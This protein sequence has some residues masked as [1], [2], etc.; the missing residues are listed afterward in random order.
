MPLHRRATRIPYALR[1]PD[2]SRLDLAAGSVGALL[3]RSMSA[4]AQ[5]TPLSAARRSHSVSLAGLGYL[6]V[7]YVIWGSTYLAIRVAVREGAGFPPFAM[8]GSRVLAAGLVLLV[9]AALRGERLRLRRDEL[10]ILAISGLLLWVGGNGLVVWAEQHAGSGY[11]ALLVSASPLWVAVGE[12]V[13]DPRA[14]SAMLVLS[15]LVGLG[16]VVVL[17]A[18]AL[19]TGAQMDGAAALALLFAS[20]TWS[21]GSLLQHRRP[22][23]VSPLASSAYQ[24][25]FGGVGFLAIIALVRE[26]LPTPSP[27]ALLALGYLVVFGSLLSKWAEVRSVSAPMSPT[28]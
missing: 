12:A 3:T 24:L 18:P 22:V 27:E 1:C 23:D 26:P 28:C 25:L 14:P 7:V 4:T 9:W 6:A 10:W 8:S 13:L 19:G 11:A 15:L 21:A 20:I 17:T 16:G 2:G 5:S